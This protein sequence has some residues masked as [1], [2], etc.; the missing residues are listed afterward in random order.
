MARST[1]TTTKRTGFGDDDGPH[2]SN[3]ATA[4]DV[5]ARFVNPDEDERLRAP[6][7]DD[8]PPV[9]KVAFTRPVVKEFAPLGTGGKVGHVSVKNVRGAGLAS[10]AGLLLF[11]AVALCTG[12]GALVDNFVLNKPATPW[13]LIVGFFVGLLA[14]GIQ[15]ARLIQQLK[16]GDNGGEIGSGGK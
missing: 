9:P 13:G 4:D 6:K 14:G 3:D 8:L 10:S 12:L 16:Q 2:Q 1:S 15:L 11:A 7:A 5:A